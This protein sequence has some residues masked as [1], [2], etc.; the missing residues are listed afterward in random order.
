VTLVLGRLRIDKIGR[1]DVARMVRDVMAGRT[2]VSTPQ[3]PWRG[4]GVQGGRGT[5]GQALA[6]LSAVLAFAVA[7]G[8]RDDNPARGVKKPPIGKCAG[9]SAAP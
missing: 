7:R 1:T 6:V 4:R 9:A 8:L 2:A 5:A 3:R